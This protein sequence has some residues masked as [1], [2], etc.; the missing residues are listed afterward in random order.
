MNNEVGSPNP[1]LVIL[2]ENGGPQH[3]GWYIREVRRAATCCEAE[4][5]D[6]AGR[7][8][9]IDGVQRIRTLALFYTGELALRDLE[10]PRS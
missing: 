3:E 4:D 6:N 10:R 5:P 7:L 9:I 2:G 8:E 1:S